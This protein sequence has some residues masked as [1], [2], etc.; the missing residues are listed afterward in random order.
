M[1]DS[2]VRLTGG[3]YTI[4]LSDSAEKLQRQPGGGGWGMV[5]VVNSWFE[6]AGD[7]ATLRGTRRTQRELSIPFAAFG[8]NAREVEANLR[9]LV[10]IIRN[11]FLVHI[12][13]ADGQSFSITAVYDSGLEGAYTAA[14]DKWATAT[15]VLKCPD[16]YWVSDASQAFIIAPTPAASAFLALY[17]GLPVASS[18]AFGTVA[19]TN[20]GDVDSRP[21]WTV[22]GP[23]DALTLA[24]NGV[25]LI[26]NKVLSST[27]IVTIQYVNGGWTITDQTGLNLYT[28]LATSPPAVFPVLPPGGSVVTATMT[29]TGVA[30]FIQCVYPERREIIY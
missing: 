12:D 4:T 11:P 6:G 2:K 8:A 25:G 28:Y 13:L 23:G 1:I 26:L 7:G 18:A 29:G 16:P 19:A 5:P 20:I 15:L 17:S 27:D 10:R 3:G 30:S 22:H 24:V 21:T 14:P 9:Q